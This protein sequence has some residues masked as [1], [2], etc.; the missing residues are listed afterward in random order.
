MALF[1]KIEFFIII[2]EYVEVAPDFL[3]YF[4]QTMHLL[5]QDDTLMTISAWNEHGAFSAISFYKP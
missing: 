3:R 1:P 2:E 5:E 4:S